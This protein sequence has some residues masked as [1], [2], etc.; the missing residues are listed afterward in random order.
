MI[1]EVMKIITSLLNERP[2]DGFDFMPPMLNWVEVLLLPTSRYTII[3]NP[4][5]AKRWRI[6]QVLRIFIP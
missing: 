6:D 4:K 5:E 1:D 2:K 3:K